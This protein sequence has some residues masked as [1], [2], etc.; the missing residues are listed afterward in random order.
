M[1]RKTKQLEAQLDVLNKNF[2]AVVSDLAERT[3]EVDTLR[4]R[5]KLELAREAAARE[6]AEARL[7][8][9]IEEA[10]ARLVEQQSKHDAEAAEMA[11]LLG[12]LQTQWVAKKEQYAALA[13]VG[14]ASPH[15]NGHGAAEARAAAEHAAAAEALRGELRQAR[16]GAA[17][18]A[19]AHVQ[20]VAAVRA[21]HEAERRRAADDE[22]ENARLRRLCGVACLVVLLLAL[23]IAG[24]VVYLRRFPTPLSCALDH[25]RPVKFKIDVTDFWAPRISA[26]L[27]AVLNVGNR[28]LLDLLLLEACKVTVY[29]A[30]TGLKLGSASS[31]ALTI[32][33]FSSTTVS[34]NVLGIGANAPQ[35]E[36]RRIASTFLEKKWLLLTLSLIHISEPTRPY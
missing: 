17:A 10:E 35:P 30:R 19:A 14:G 25:V 28:N 31:N 16:D 9:A 2:G 23:A 8:G 6:E 7:G 5:S 12:Q 4:A 11:A 3:A 24:A 34:V 33:P 26:T 27:Q 32:S 20:E 22:I 21:E 36:Q 29:E 15:A 13:R 1:S 18:A